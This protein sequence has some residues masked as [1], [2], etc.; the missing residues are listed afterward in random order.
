MR[1]CSNAVCTVGERGNSSQRVISTALCFGHSDGLSGVE[2]VFNAFVSA[3]E[4]LGYASLQTWQ[5]YVVCT[6]GADKF[7]A[8]P[9]RKQ[10]RKHVRRRPRFQ[11][12]RDASSQQVFLPPPP[13]RQGAKG[14]SRL[15][16]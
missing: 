2:H 1:N 15:S 9:G 4:Y 16:E 10:A 14:N 3:I 5:F 12:H 11:Q 8:R 7:L 6:R 13:A